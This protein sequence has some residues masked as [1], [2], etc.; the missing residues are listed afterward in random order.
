MIQKNKDINYLLSDKRFDLNR[1]EVKKTITQ[2]LKENLINKED[3]NTII[4]EDILIKIKYNSLKKCKVKASISV[5]LLIIGL[6]LKT[7]IPVFSF[8]IIFGFII[9]ISSAVGLHSNR[10]TKRQINYIKT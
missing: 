2:L 8:F 3:Y 1:F 7:A 5:L 4:D 9:L 10:L 6:L